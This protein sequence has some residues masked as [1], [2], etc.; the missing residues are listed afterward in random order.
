MWEVS[1]EGF[2]NRNTYVLK[3]LVN[4][5]SARVE[6]LVSGNKCMP[7]SKESAVL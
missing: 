2:H 6:T 3:L 4:V 5:V 7:V 1:M